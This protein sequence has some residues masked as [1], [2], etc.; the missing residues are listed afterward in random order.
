MKEPGNAQ[1][2]SGILR[3]L[4]RKQEQGTK[5]RRMKEPGKAQESSGFLKIL[6]RKQE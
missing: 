3:I 4:S 1:E 5:V 2:S 6:S